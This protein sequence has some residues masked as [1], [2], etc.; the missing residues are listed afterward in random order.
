M[1]M[2]VTLGYVQDFLDFKTSSTPS[3]P[4]MF[5]SPSSP[6]L[7]VDQQ[8]GRLKGIHLPLSRLSLQSRP[9]RGQTRDRR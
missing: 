4:G 7:K 9:V 6:D 5:Q 8:G 1:I 3:L 2:L